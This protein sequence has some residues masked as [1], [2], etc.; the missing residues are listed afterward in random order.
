[1]C[2]TRTLIQLLDV[3]IIMIKTSI[4][5]AIMK[6]LEEQSC[7]GDE[8]NQDNTV[9]QFSALNNLTIWSIFS[10]TTT[11][12]QVEAVKID[13][14]KVKCTQKVVR[15][16]TLQSLSNLLDNRKLVSIA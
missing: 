8:L 5:I 4:T 14:H 6:H 16:F 1:M 11:N 13:E 3:Y 12:T 2:L 7:I 15:E 10:F 9:F